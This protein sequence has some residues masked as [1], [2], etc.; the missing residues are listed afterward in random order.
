MNESFSARVVLTG[1]G[2]PLPVPDRAGPGVVVQTTDA[3]MQ[4]D[5]GRATVLRLADAGI[6]PAALNGVFLTHH[7][8]DHTTDLGDVLISSWLMNAEAD[9]DVITP[10]GLA[11]DFV[12]DALK[13]LTGDIGFRQRHRKSANVPEPQVIEFD[14]RRVPEQVWWRGQVTVDAVAV[15]HEPV[16]NAVAYRVNT[17][18]GAIVVSG[19]TRACDEVESLAHGAR[20]LVHEVIDPARVPASRAHTI[21]YHAAVTEVGAL[22]QRAGVPV[23]L[24]THLW[25]APSNEDQSQSFLDGIRA[26]GYT[27]EV[28]VGTDLVSVS[29]DASSHRITLPDTVPLP[30][31]HSPSPELPVR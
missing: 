5:T 31:L 8:S 20:V 30:A 1:T 9:P 19:D 6:S 18:I 3:T 24:L 17:P 26:G 11:A 23:L 22:A 13:P 25:P 15:R 29:I 12:R 4:F 21:E 27:G 28:V 10:N 16:E 7:H 2:T 14:P